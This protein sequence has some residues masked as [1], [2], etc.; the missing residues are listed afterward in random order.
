MRSGTLQPIPDGDVLAQQGE[1][2]AF[3]VIGTVRVHEADLSLLARA[4]LLLACGAGVEVTAVQG[5]G[6]GTC[7][8]PR[9]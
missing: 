7:R 1:D 8:A 3:L 6:G 2:R 9:G 5:G 4:P